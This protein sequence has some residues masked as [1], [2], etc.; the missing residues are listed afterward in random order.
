MPANKW[1]PEKKE[2]F[3]RLWAE[4]R[5][6]KSICAE[7]GVSRSGLTLM[8]QRLCLTPR[9]S[10]LLVKRRFV[11]FVMDE[12]MYVAAMR[13]VFGRHSSIGSYIRQLIRRDIGLPHEQ[14]R[15]SRVSVHKNGSQLVLFDEG[16]K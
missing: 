9:R 16:E 2:L 8:R 14:S 11:N 4:G 5:S 12:P 1:T 13:E 3:K 10:P 15:G 6:G 7:L